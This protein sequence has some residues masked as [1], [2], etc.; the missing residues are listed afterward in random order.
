M[1][2]VLE[3]EGGRTLSLQR[4]SNRWVAVAND[5]DRGV[6]VV[7]SKD[8]IDALIKAINALA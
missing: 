1:K 4:M 6:T 5:R 3:G 8:D 7:L 2:L